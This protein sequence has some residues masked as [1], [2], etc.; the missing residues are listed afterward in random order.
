MLVLGST[1][2]QY[3]LGLVTQLCPIPGDPVDCSLPG[4]SV[5]GDSPGKNTGVGCHALLQGL[6]PT[7]G[8][9]PGLPHCRRI[10][11][12]SEPP[13]KPLIQ[14]KFI[15]S[16]LYLQRLYLQI[17][18]HSQVL[19]RYGLRGPCVTQ[20]RPWQH[21]PTS[22][23]PPAAASTHTPFSVLLLLFSPNLAPAHR[24]QW[25]KHDLAISSWVPMPPRGSEQ[26]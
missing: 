5:H 1:V 25:L 10:L 4:P 21:Q 9:N 19:G 17:R 11:H 24:L 26:L 14:Y 20:P 16:W 8:S 18:S 2:I 15:L 12:L 13:G 22:S 7:Q 23:T 3:V 6:F